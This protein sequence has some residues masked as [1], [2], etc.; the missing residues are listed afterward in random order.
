MI[1]TSCAGFTDGQRFLLGVLMRQRQIMG[2]KPEPVTESSETD[3][4]M[5]ELK[6]STAF[7]KRSHI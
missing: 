2:Q 1:N 5:A 6:K 3:S 4:L 7:V